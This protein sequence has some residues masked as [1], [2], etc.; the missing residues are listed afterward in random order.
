MNQHRKLHAVT[1][2]P[3][4]SATHFVDPLLPPLWLANLDTHAG[5]IQSGI[6]L[7]KNMS[8]TCSGPHW[9]KHLSNKDDPFGWMLRLALCHVA[10]DAVQI[11]FTI[12][13][14][15]QRIF[16]N[17]VTLF[18]HQ[19]CYLYLIYFEAGLT[20]ASFTVLKKMFS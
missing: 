10:I 7:I 9:K 6:P 5:Y 12:R 14:S 3:Q 13:L 8:P 2:N 1:V 16:I 4:S 11:L 15:A 17:T 19:Y 18:C 20:F